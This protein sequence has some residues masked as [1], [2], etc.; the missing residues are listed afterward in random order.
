MRYGAENIFQNL[1]G[2]KS[3]GASLQMPLANACDDCRLLPRQSQE[4]GAL[5]TRTIGVGRWNALRL[6]TWSLHPVH[7]LGKIVSGIPRS[8]DEVA[9]R[10]RVGDNQRRLLTGELGPVLRRQS[11]Q[12]DDQRDN[13]S[14]PEGVIVQVLRLPHDF[15]FQ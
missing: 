13:E 7:E 2:E 12:D 15:S 10:I 11:S 1:G 14:D 8:T 3:K 9:G 6:G 5:G 4:L